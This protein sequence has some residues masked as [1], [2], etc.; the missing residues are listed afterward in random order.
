MFLQQPGG[1][2]GCVANFSPYFLQPCQQPDLQTVLCKG[3]DQIARWTCKG[4]LFLKSSI[5]GGHVLWHRG[6]MGEIPLPSG[7]A[8]GKALSKRDLTP[9]N[10]AGAAGLEMCCRF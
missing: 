1:A 8:E 2:C 10:S 7:A 9:M 3:S 4:L 5:E 6:H